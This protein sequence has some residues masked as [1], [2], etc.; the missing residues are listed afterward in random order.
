[1][2]EE[3]AKPHL[4]ASA[5]RTAD[6][7]HGPR[8]RGQN[9]ISSQ[10]MAPTSPVQR[11]MGKRERA[12]PHLFTAPAWQHQAAMVMVHYGYWPLPQ[13]WLWYSMDIDPYL[14]F[15]L[16]LIILLGTC[17]WRGAEISLNLVWIFQIIWTCSSPMLFL[18]RTC[19]SM[20]F[21]IFV[22]CR[23]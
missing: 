12:T 11:P 5:P 1:M 20:S 19:K 21:G 9:R 23:R 18:T 3:R 16:V 6:S 8:E 22:S 10:L 13:L 14:I 17:P 7:D 15:Q 2:A 4:L